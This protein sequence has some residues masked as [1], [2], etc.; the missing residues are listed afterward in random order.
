[1]WWKVSNTLRNNLSLINRSLSHHQVEPLLC[2]CQTTEQ[3]QS[4]TRWH[5]CAKYNR[6][7]ESHS[8][9]SSSSLQDFL[10][11]VCTVILRV[12]VWSMQSNGW[13]LVRKNQNLNWG[14]IVSVG[15]RL[16]RSTSLLTE[17]FATAL[18]VGLFKKGWKKLL[19]KCFKQHSSRCPLSTQGILLAKEVSKACTSVT[20]HVEENTG[21]GK[22]NRIWNWHFF[23][24]RF[25]TSLRTLSL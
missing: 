23:T 4:H 25:I 18:S 13:C 2:H 20:A 5:I 17:R 16:K 14:G 11:L 22:K 3:P 24:H 1:M 19:L 8:S 7:W 9:S 12:L 10:A 6:R 15:L 21:W